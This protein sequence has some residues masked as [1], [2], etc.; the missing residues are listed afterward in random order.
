MQLQ[1]VKAELRSIGINPDS[2]S[3]IISSHLDFVEYYRANSKI[4]FVYSK[5]LN[6][7]L[8]GIQHPLYHTKLMAALFKAS[9]PTTS[10]SEYD[11]ADAF[12][13]SDLGFFKSSAGSKIYHSKSYFP[14]PE[15][16][17]I[18]SQFEQL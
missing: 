16:C 14:I 8:I 13:D 17:I 4:D 7:Y 18:S 10:L 15:L 1:E 11:R 9:C 12:I 2:I 3:T 6:S 5:M